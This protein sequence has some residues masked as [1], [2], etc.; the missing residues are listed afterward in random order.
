VIKKSDLSSGLGGWQFDDQTNYKKPSNV[1]ISLLFNVHLESLAPL[2][3][4]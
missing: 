3:H 4:S 2:R 1:D